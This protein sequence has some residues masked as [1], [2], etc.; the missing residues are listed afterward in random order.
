[1]F[2]CSFL[3]WSHGRHPM[4][5]H[6]CS[7]V[8]P[9]CVA[10]VSIRCA[11]IHWT[12]V[13]IYNHS[14]VWMFAFPGSLSSGSDASADRPPVAL[15]L[16]SGSQAMAC[17]PAHLLLSAI[18]RSHTLRVMGAKHQK[19]PWGVWRLLSACL[20]KSPSLLH[21]STSATIE[22]NGLD[23][24]FSMILPCMFCNALHAHYIFLLPE[25]VLM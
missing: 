13:A 10:M 7:P 9:S 12:S 17:A 21:V 18:F 14:T 2:P 22:K 4:C 11:C 23:I 25:N 16:S 1:M 20:L 19:Q 5:L 3:A 8:P 6:R 15:C 24:E